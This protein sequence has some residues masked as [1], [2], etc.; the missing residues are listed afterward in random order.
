MSRT[1]D[2]ADTKLPV[3]GEVGSEGGSYGDPTLQVATHEGDLGKTA[4]AVEPE[5]VESGASDVRKYP[6]EAPD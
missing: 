6:T 4:E 5:T 2:R 1:D 3:T